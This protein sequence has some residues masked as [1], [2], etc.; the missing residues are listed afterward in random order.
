MFTAFAD[1]A[2]YLYEQ[3][4]PVM[5]SEHRI[6]TAMITGGAS[7]PKTTLKPDEKVT[8]HKKCSPC[9]LQFPNRKQVYYR[10]IR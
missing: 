2:Q 1:T 6:H 4:S 8:T 3:L 7:L 10:R 5:L 9:F